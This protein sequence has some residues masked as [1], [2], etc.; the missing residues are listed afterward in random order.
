MTLNTLRL[1]QGEEEESESWGEG[2]GEKERGC[3][4]RVEGD[5]RETSVEEAC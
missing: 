4:T 1:D 5:E 3:A 2:R